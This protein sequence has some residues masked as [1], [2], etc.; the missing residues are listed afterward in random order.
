MA[1]ILNTSLVTAAITCAVLLSLRKE[2]G[3]LSHY[4]YNGNT[5]LW[6]EVHGTDL[7]ACS[8]AICTVNITSESCSLMIRTISVIELQLVL[9]IINNL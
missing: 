8:V 4:G 1:R 6:C 9:L 5:V 2:V 3:G 7:E